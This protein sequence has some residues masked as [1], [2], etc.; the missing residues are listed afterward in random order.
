MN[1]HYSDV[2]QW[3]SDS[4][5][6]FEKLQKARE[7][8]PHWQPH[9]QN[10]RHP[11]HV[12]PRPESVIDFNFKRNQQEKVKALIELGRS[13]NLLGKTFKLKERYMNCSYD[14]IKSGI[15]FEIIYDDE[16][17]SDGSSTLKI[18]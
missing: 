18:H 10:P 2:G 13:M 3:E 8:V 17:R 4:A 14:L 12:A 5:T 16:G 9:M 11:S 6:E 7:A 15:R 1:N